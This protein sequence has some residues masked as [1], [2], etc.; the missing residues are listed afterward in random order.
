MPKKKTTVP[1]VG[2]E[3]SLSVRGEDSSG[4]P[5]QATS[6]A[7]PSIDEALQF[8]LMCGSGMPGVDALAYFYPGVDSASL[9]DELRVW[10]TSKRVQT[11]TLKVQGKSWQDRSLDERISFALEKHYA[12]QAY[13]L[14]SRNYAT[15]TG[16]DKLKADT[17]RQVLE[18]KLA[19]TSGKMDPISTWFADVAS[20]K[21]KLPAPAVMKPP[22]A[23]LTN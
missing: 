15:L 11:A 1:V 9:M 16:T 23:E 19:G 13:F 8:A 21:V 14:Y 18:A 20:G 17:C 7:R 10:Q 22:K 6:L 2:S 12:E 4:V 5:A 3:V